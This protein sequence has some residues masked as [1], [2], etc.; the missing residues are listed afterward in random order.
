VFGGLW[1]SSWHRRR[2]YGCSPYYGGYG[3]GYYPRYR[4]GGLGLVLFLAAVDRF[5]DRHF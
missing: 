2:Y 5:F 1:W 3:R 4:F